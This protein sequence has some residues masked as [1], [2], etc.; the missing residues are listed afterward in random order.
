MTAA[1]DILNAI[2][3]AGIRLSIGDNG[4]LKCAGDQAAI[5]QWLPEIRDHKSELVALLAANEPAPVHRRWLITRPNGTRFSLSRNPPCTLVDVT[6]DYPGCTIAPE[7][8][9]APGPALSPDDLAVAHAL[10]RHWGE[11]DLTTGNEWLAGLVRDPARLE[12]MRQT[13]LAAGVARY[14]PAPAPT[15]E[16]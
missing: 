2:D 1:I 3:Q 7:A 11:E 15:T 5:A 8:D 12:G 6:A 14:A 10:L 4:K 9:P 13:A 16:P